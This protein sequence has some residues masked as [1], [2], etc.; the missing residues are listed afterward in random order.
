M[1]LVPKAAYDAFVLKANSGDIQY[2]R[3]INNVDVQD[4]G[5]VTI[6]NDDNINKIG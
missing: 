5:K 6:R 1:Y 3:Q 2:M 4:G